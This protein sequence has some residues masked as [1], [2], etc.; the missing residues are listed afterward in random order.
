MSEIDVALEHL[1]EVIKNS[2][3]Y[4]EYHK[5]LELV[6][7]DPQ[8][9][10]QIDNFRQRNYEMQKSEDMAFYKLTEFEK[11][12]KGFRENPLVDSFLAAELDFC[13]MLQNLDYRL[14]EAMD[15]E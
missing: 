2:E 14:I 11:E 9:K 4:K 13:R 12:F 15:F 6:K 1:I 7:Q 10:A 3:V 5:Q 8:L